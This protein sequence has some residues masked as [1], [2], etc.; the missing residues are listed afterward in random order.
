MTHRRMRNALI[1]RRWSI[2]RQLR[3][4]P[5]YGWITKIE[6]LGLSYSSGASDLVDA[7]TYMTTV[8]RQLIIGVDPA[9]PGSDKTVIAVRNGNELTFLDVPVM[10]PD[11]EQKVKEIVEHKRKIFD[12]LLLRIIRGHS[13]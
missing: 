5:P 1:Y 2:E 4:V 10:D 7:F 13:I 8:N 9:K 12:D 3:W 11:F 6:A